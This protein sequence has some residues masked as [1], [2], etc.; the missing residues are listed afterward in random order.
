MAGIARKVGS[1]DSRFCVFVCTPLYVLAR[2]LFPLSSSLDRQNEGKRR[3]FHVL[4]LHS[5]TLREE[6][7]RSLS[8]RCPSVLLTKVEWDSDA[9]LNNGKLEDLVRLALKRLNV[10]Y[11]T[12]SSHLV[13]FQR[14]TL[15]CHEH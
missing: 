9:I 7:S 1:K 13:W 5:P 4:F 10:S 8:P 3:D 14:E 11:L 2:V 12:I 6:K 15:V